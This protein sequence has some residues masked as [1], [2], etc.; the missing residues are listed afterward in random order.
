[1]QRLGAPDGNWQRGEAAKEL[2]GQAAP[3]R[4]RGTAI[5]RAAESPGKAASVR[6]FTSAEC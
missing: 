3:G 1:M 4:A 5:S 6:D 2:Y